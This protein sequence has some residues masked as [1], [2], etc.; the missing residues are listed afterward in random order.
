MCR[1]FILHIRK[2]G[3]TMR[4][5]PKS[6]LCATDFSENSYLSV[7]YAISMA[8]EFSAKLFLCHILPPPYAGLAEGYPTDPLSQQ[9]E[10]MDEASVRFSRWME[11]QSIEWAPL[12]AVGDAAS[13]I[14]RLAE[15]NKVELAICATHGRSGLKRLILGSLTERLMRSLSCPVLVVRPEEGEIPQAPSGDVRFQRILI[16][17]DFSPDSELAFRYGLSLAQEYMSELHL[18]HVVEPL[19]YKHLLIHSGKTEGVDLTRQHLRGP[20]KEKLSGMVPLE[21]QNWCKPV[22]VLLAGQPYEEMT[23]YAL[24]NDIDLIVLG[25][26]GQSLIQTLFMGSTT[27]RVIRQASCPVLSVQPV[28][29]NRAA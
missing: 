5:H 29:W 16:G 2:E 20:L 11:G 26:R 13:E 9:K 23:K 15:E 3:K 21:A 10:L 22:T 1:S 8:R 18:V 14:T 27:D 19:A 28:Y 25:L 4:V 24:V 17:C 6:I 7:S 12:L